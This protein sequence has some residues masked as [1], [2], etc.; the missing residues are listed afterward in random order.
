MGNVKTVP[1]EPA[2]LN[3]DFLL[4]NFK[5]D[6]SSFE[7]FKAYVKAVQDHTHF[8]VVKS[9]DLTVMSYF[10]P[11]TS[12]PNGLYF[13]SLNP[14]DVLTGNGEIK[15]STKKIN[16]KAFMEKGDFKNVMDEIVSGTRF[17]F[18]D[19]FKVYL[20]SPNCFSTLDRF[21]LAG[22]FLSKPDIIRDSIIARQLG[23]RSQKCTIVY[24]EI[25]KVK[26]AFAILS[27]KYKNAGQQ[28]LI[29]CIDKIAEDGTI[30]RPVCKYW[31]INHFI[32]SI[33]IEFPEKAKELMK[34]YKTKHKFI[35]GLLLETSD[36]GDSSVKIRSTWRYRNNRVICEEVHQ[37]HMGNLNV[38]AL[39]KEVDDTIFS[40]YRKLPEALCN[41]MLQDLTDESW[42]LTTFD[43]RDKN[44]QMI[45]NVLVN[46]FD[47]MGINSSIGKKEA[48]ALLNSV[49]NLFNFNERYTA[50]DVAFILMCT[51]HL[52]VGNSYKCECYAKAC[53]KAPFIKYK[54]EIED[55]TI[56]LM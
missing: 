49:Y 56:R 9:N 33:Y 32:T 51:P 26:K 14:D 13:Y 37:R 48:K 31:E 53:G 40:K 45:H 54:T 43:G 46:A 11:Q 50:Y 36:T 10:K 18:F 52:I 44:A 39:L 35:P 21:G 8:E 19:G 6:G 34:T 24:R 23:L 28:I 30:G 25:N 55:E 22:H 16:K 15:I 7:E 41:L 4:E 27:G 42:D 47:D 17:C 29:D 2:Q 20:T 12:D 5:V 3:E 1:T 38:D